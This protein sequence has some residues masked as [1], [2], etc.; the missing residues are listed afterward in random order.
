MRTKKLKFNGKFT[1]K[2]PFYKKINKLKHK[3]SKHK[4]LKKGKGLD[5]NF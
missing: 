3:K 4:N 1:K 5:N 2:L